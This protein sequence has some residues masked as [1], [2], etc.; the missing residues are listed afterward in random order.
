VALVLDEP[1]SPVSVAIR[2][3]ADREIRARFGEHIENG[4]KRGLGLLRS[5]K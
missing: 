4:A 3:I 2:D 1:R 5:R